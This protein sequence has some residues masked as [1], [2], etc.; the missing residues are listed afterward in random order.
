MGREREYISHAS[1]SISSVCS[2]HR[3]W[4]ATPH[5]TTSSERGP[6]GGSSNGSRKFR[7]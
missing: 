6:S 7:L 3:G 4:G 1:T 2:T 5:R